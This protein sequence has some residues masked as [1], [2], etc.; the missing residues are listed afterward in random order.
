[1]QGGAG[2]NV[3]NVDDSGSSANRIGTLTSSALTGLGMTGGISYS[4]MSAVNITLGAGTESLT[5]ASTIAGQTTVFAGAGPDTINVQSTSGPTTLWGGRGNL[6]ANV[7]SLQPAQ[8]GIV[9]NIR[10]PLTV[11]GA[12]GVNALNVDDSGSAS[13]KTGTLTSTTITGLN[14]AGGITY[15]GMAAVNIALGQGSV[16]FI[17]ASTQTGTTSV[18]S[19]GGSD[20]VDVQSTRGA[21]TVSGGAGTDTIN[22]F[23]TGAPATINAGSGNA[24]INIFSVGGT[25]AINNNNAVATINIQSIGGATSVYGDGRD[26]VNVGSKAPQ[27]GG[28]VSAISAPLL[29]AGGRGRDVLN[30]DGSGSNL[31][32]TDTLTAT[33][34]S[35]LGMPNGITYGNLAALAISL[36]SGGDNFTVLGTQT[37]ST[38]INAGAGN[39]AFNV[40]AVSGN[41]LVNGGAG[42]RRVHRR[43]H[44]GRH[45][46][47]DQDHQRPLNAG[48]WYGE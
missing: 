32:E 48:W 37:G 15:S 14:M 38:L 20:I 24:V 21:T 35:G 18:Q 30:V 40:Q 13:N 26:V 36:G 44:L 25:T 47:D 8:G 46:A 28:V 22:V 6:T 12:S 17:I 42:K 41:T 2:T 16:H 7:G 4:H 23:S 31:P 43:Q 1:M 10:A 19:G 3:L 5:V 39:N 34:L 11:N 45:G 33:T 29:I 27:T 9:D